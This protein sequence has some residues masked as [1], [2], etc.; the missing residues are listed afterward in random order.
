MNAS[1]R[2]I[3]EDLDPERVT[4]TIGVS[5][6][7]SGRKGDPIVAALS[8]GRTVSRPTSAGY[9]VLELPG[10]EIAE[11]RLSLEKLL[12]SAPDPTEWKRLQA[13]IELT[14]HD[15][16]PDLTPA[17]LLGTPTLARLSERGVVVAINTD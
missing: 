7:E 3:A 4:R 13:H 15:A 12:D 6:T 1:L 8:G 11:L 9:W 16:P 5:P 17:T 10:S 14:V 2:A